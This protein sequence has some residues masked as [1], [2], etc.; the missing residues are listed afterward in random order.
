[1]AD[2]QIG[3]E[4]FQ[5]AYLSREDG[6]K[7][8]W[9]KGNVEKTKRTMDQ[10]QYQILRNLR[11]FFDLLKRAGKI[12]GGLESEI[13][14]FF[15]PDVHRRPDISYFSEKQEDEMAFGRTQVPLFV[16]EIIFT[17]DQMNLV[18]GKMEDFRKAGV[19][20]VWHI[21]PKLEIVHVY[22]GKELSD[23]YVCREDEH[24]SAAPVLNEFQIAVNDIFKKPL[25]NEK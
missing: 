21:F 6:F 25:V 19:K 17:N 13:D 1:M 4:Q 16:I 3:W 12:S 18:H 11:R 14:T 24:C 8:E 23:M 20:V 2:A 9:V 22:G 15:L 10:R 7:Y 5:V